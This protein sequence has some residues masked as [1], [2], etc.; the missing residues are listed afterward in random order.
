MYLQFNKSKGKNGKVYQSVLLCKKY[1][2]KETGQP[3]TEVVL[4]L[5]KYGLNDKIITALKTSLNKAKG[6]LIDSE[7][8]KINKTIDFGFI[9]LLL[10]L[11]DKL[12]IRET[13]E[14]THGSGADIILLMLMG[15]IIT[16]GSRL[17]VYRWIKRNHYLAERLNINVESLKE[18]ELYFELGEISAVQAQIERKW[19]VYHRKHRNTIYLYDITNAYF[20]GAEN[21]FSVFDRNRDTGKEKR[22]IT[23]GLVT[24]QAGFPLKIQVFDGSVLE[25]KTV[26][27]QLIAVK[28][29]FGAET[30]IWVG[31]TDRQFRLHADELPDGKCIMKSTVAAP[32]G[33]EAQIREKYNVL[34]NVEHAFRDMRADKLNTGSLF[35]INEARIRGDIFVCMLSYAVVKEME[36]VIDPWLKAYNKKNNC[37][38]S[39]HD[40]TDELNNIKVSKLEIGYQ[41]KKILAPDMNEIQSQICQLFHLGID[42]ITDM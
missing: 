27:E 3:K 30:L 8:I 21:A 42:E 38:L 37:Q 17:H 40:I 24:D 14:K 15:K 34:Q 39:F 1:R 28:E 11:I 23:I 19:A 7:D 29:Q 35:H 33:D 12:R 16:R 18:D 26:N 36:T 6:V 41:L 22:P 2:D 5:S 4:N 10:T 9:H 25:H 32:E 20:K 31:D 13:L